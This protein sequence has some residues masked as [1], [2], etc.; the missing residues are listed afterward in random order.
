MVHRGTGRKGGERV[1]WQDIIPYA[2]RLR[3][4]W[5]LR[6]SGP[7]E[8]SYLQEVLYHASLGIEFSASPGGKK[9]YKSVQLHWPNL[10]N[11]FRCG[12]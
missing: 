11:Q 4:P 8:L 6:C 7:R 5:C 2:F 12:V 3:S 10:T 9:P 1:G